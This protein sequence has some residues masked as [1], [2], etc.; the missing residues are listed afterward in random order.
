MSRPAPDAGLAIAG[1]LVA[2]SVGA[3][4]PA[5]R[6]G[7]LGQPAIW[8]GL[9]VAP[10]AL[11]GALTQQSAAWLLAG[12]PA[13]LAAV[14]IGWPETATPRALGVAGLAGVAAGFVMA[15]LAVTP[16]RP[17]ST[18]RADLLAALPW[19]V[20]L[21]GMV[22]LA[23][24]AVG[25]LGRARLRETFGAH[26]D[27]MLVALAGV[28]FVLWA[29]GT[30]VLVQRHVLTALGAPGAAREELELWAARQRDPVRAAWGFLAALAVAVASGLAL[31]L[32][33]RQTR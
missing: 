18:R 11:A 22:P 21:A 17:G 32:Y 26:A 29:G 23:R 4:L 33:L 24:L 2:W 19:A 7:L 6:L 20:V 27:H 5:L 28:A 9:A 31:A 12:L 16:R 10:L 25:T 30:W 15:H 13:G 1:V 8:A 3:L 14:W